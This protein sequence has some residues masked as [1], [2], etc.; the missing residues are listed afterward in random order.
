MLAFKFHCLS[1]NKFTS[2]GGGGSTSLV[3]AASKNNDKISTF[4]ILFFFK[5]PNL[6]ILLKHNKPYRATPSQMQH[7]LL[8][9]NERL[10]QANA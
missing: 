7:Q 10:A 9:P 1:Y 3:Q 5:I 8:Y 6:D 2:G 4:R